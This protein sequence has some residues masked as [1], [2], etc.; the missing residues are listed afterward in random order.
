MRARYFDLYDLAPV[1]YFTLNENGVIVSANL[2]AATLLGIARGALAKEP[3]THFILPDDQDIY[4]RHKKQ[5]VETGAPEVCELRMRREGG[6]GV[7]EPLWVRLE[8]TSAKDEGSGEGVVRVVMI[9]V[10]ERRRAEEAKRVADEHAAGMDRLA[11]LG[12]LA[13]SVGHEINNPLCYTLC[14]IETL[15]DD[16]PRLADA[17]RRCASALRERVGAAAYRE[18][19]GDGAE[20][21]EEAWLSDAL[22]RA[23]DAREGVRRIRD[24]ASDLRTFARSDSGQPSKVDVKCAIEAA[25]GVAENEFKFRARL[26]KEFGDVPAVSASVSRLSQ[27]F[28]NLL[29]NAAH[30]IDE[31]DV[32]ANRIAVR[33]WTAGNDVFAEVV[34]SG[35]GIPA[36]NLAR[37]FEPFFTTSGV[38]KGTGLGLAICRKI[39]TELGGDIR[40][41]S[42]IGVGSRFVVRLPL[43]GEAEE[44]NMH[45]GGTEGHKSAEAQRRE[46]GGRK[47]EAGAGVRG[48]ILVVDDEPGVLTALLRMFGRDHQVVTAAN[49]K[50]AQAILERDRAFDVVLCDVMMPGMSGTEL[51]EW[52]AKLAPELARRTVFITGGAFTPK[53][54]AYVASVGNPV[55]EKPFDVANLQKLVSDRVGG[56]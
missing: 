50:V 41:E 24:V 46:K 5:L 45:H 8:A 7:E 36:E 17:T 2:M 11:S 4:Y 16:L 33:T 52:L 55:A 9:D 38:G 18:I 34:D 15:A 37:V 30:A 22:F 21:M 28:L 10:S 13:A 26:V 20:C 47:K 23:R 31:G 56:H 25:I 54:A 27:V 40:V 29:I 42:Q 44:E 19:V 48:R 35:K 53:A 14:N 43:G 49:G 39:V 51:H 3:L 1:G 12:L 32:A 6:E